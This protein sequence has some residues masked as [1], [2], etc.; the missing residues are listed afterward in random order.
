VAL[1]PDSARALRKIARAAA[2]TAPGQPRS[3]GGAEMQ[4]AT[5]ASKQEALLN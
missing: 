2:G 5:P 4:S 3:G 1:I